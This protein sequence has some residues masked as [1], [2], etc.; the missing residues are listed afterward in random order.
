MATWR[1]SNGAKSP[2]TSDYF[3]RPSSAEDST[4]RYVGPIYHRCQIYD[5]IRRRRVR[6]CRRISSYEIII[7]VT[8]PKYYPTDTVINLYTCA[9]HYKQVILH[10]QQHRKI[11]TTYGI[12]FSDYDDIVMIY[13]NGMSDIRPRTSGRTAKDYLIHHIGFVWYNPSYRLATEIMDP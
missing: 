10:V 5:N 6:P 13:V 7:T 8:I 11:L 4:N 9:Y 1:K 2:R 3:I 12:M